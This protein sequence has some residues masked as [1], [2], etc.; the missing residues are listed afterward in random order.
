MFVNLYGKIVEGKVVVEEEKILEKW[1][2]IL[3]WQAVN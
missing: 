1:K 2:T 3:I